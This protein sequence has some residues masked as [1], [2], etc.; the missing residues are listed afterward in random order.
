[1]VGV[2]VRRFF[3]KRCSCAAA[4]ARDHEPSSTVGRDLDHELSC[5]SDNMVVVEI[6]GVD[7]RSTC[8]VDWTSSLELGGAHSQLILSSFPELDL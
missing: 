1:V 7:G 5:G 6:V 4:N 2:V 8:I 3:G